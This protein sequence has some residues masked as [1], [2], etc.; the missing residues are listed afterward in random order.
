MTLGFFLICVCAKHNLL[1]LGQVIPL[2]TRLYPPI[3]L[4]PSKYAHHY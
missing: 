4:Q 2:N 3:T 1:Q